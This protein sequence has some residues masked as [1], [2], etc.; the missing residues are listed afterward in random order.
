MGIMQ[1]LKVRITTSIQSFMMEM[2]GFMTHG[3]VSP[4]IIFWASSEARAPALLQI[5]K[6]KYRLNQK[7]GK[8]TL[9]NEASNATANQ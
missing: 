6:I 8:F 9:C 2:I 5:R 4:G 1:T 7:F 3:V